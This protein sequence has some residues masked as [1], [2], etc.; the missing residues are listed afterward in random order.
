MISRVT[1][2]V[3]VWKSCVHRKHSQLVEYRFRRFNDFMSFSFLRLFGA[4]EEFKAWVPIIVSQFGLE[5]HLFSSLSML[6]STGQ[7]MLLP[8]V[9]LLSVSMSALSLSM[10]SVSTFQQH[11]RLQSKIHFSRFDNTSVFAV[12]SCS[13]L[14]DTSIKYRTAGYHSQL[15][16]LC[17]LVSSH[18]V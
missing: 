15:L 12:F 16:K 17:V 18:E 14:K 13:F 7:D 9:S 4:L 11:L 8:T 2:P 5:D 1:L 10:V 6:S 3:S